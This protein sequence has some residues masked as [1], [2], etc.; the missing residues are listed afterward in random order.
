MGVAG[1]VEKHSQNFDCLHLV[2][3]RYWNCPILSPL[4]ENRLG[5]IVILR[6]EIVVCMKI[7]E[8]EIFYYEY[9]FAQKGNQK[10]IKT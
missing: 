7:K 8:D 1:E 3:V 2:F 9:I 10:E 6:S 4:C 5:L